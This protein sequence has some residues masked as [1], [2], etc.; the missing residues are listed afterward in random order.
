M[1]ALDAAILMHPRTWEASGHLESFTDPLVQCIGKCKRRWRADHLEPEEG[2]AS[3]AAPSAAASWPRRASSTSCSR[4]SWARCATTPRA[5]SC[6][7]RPR[8]ASSSTSRTSCSSRARSRRSGSRRSARRSA[9][10]S[11]PA[12]SSSARAS[13]S[14]WRSSSSCRRAEAEEWHQ[15]WMDDRM[16][17]YTDLGIRPDHLQLREH[18]ADELSHYSAGDQRH[19]VPVPD[20]LVGARGNRQPDRLRPHASTPSSRARTSSTSTPRPR[21]A[22][23]RT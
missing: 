3:C 21:S 11:R 13:S 2:R 8:R 1:V 12:T 16:R 7:P 23:S 22:T 20:G 10:R 15:R 9:T 6:A 14:R 18:G 19:R 17:W 4:P 5:S